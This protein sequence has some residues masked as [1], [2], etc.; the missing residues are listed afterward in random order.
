MKVTIGFAVAA[1]VERTIDVPN[2]EAGIDV[3]RSLGFGSLLRPTSGTTMNDLRV[4]VLGVT[5]GEVLDR[6]GF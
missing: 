3:A 4:E 5:A 2:L 1:W 6:A